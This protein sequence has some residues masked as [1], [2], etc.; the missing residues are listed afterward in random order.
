MKSAQNGQNYRP[1]V[2]MRSTLRNRRM[3][4]LARVP[5]LVDTTTPTNGASTTAAAAASALVWAAPLRSLYWL[6]R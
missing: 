3:P 5:R 4:R 1:L 6:T 2:I